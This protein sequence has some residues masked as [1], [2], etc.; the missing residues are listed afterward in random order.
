MYD[1]LINQKVFGGFYQV[2]THGIFIGASDLSELEERLFHEVEHA[3]SGNTFIATSEPEVSYDPEKKE[4]FFET[5]GKLI[6]Q[7]ELTE[8][9]GNKRK[10][11]AQ[12]MR[13]GLVFGNAC[14]ANER[15][16]WL[17]EAVTETIAANIRNSTSALDLD[18][19]GV[20]REGERKMFKALVR[21]GKEGIPFQ[22]F[23]DAYYEDYDPNKPQG[24][25]IPA[26]KKLNAAIGTAYAPGF[27]T[28]L[29]KYIDK[30]SPKEALDLLYNDWQKINDWKK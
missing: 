7:L 16:S 6:L 15:F 22:L 5:M 19:P 14:V 20:A 3:L 11:S 12:A 26:W 8:E 30:H 28:K 10:V 18:V 23:V 29:D 25:R 2:D 13:M 1:E 24:E 21:Q 17:N 4:D 9:E 27:L